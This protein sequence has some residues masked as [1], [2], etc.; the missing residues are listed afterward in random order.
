MLM[1]YRTKGQNV[2]CGLSIRLGIT[3]GFLLLISCSP[4]PEARQERTELVPTVLVPTEWRPSLEQVQTDVEEAYTTDA[5]KSQRALNRAA[6]NMADLRDAQLFI[7]YISLMQRLDA[8]GKNDLFNEQKLWLVQRAE[9]ARAAVVSKGGSLESLE[10]ASA[11]RSIT[12]KRL[13]ELESRLTQQP[14]QSGNT[15]G[16][17][18]K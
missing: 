15:P 7:T 2:G 9:S 4:Q 6:Q 5:N 14:T 11:F 1:T 12:E 10:Y 8:K 13:A 3:I 16:R 18:E 17:G